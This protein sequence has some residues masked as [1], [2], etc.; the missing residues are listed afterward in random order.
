[1]R[2]I[3]ALPLPV[4]GF[5]AACGGGGGGGGGSAP[6]WVATAHSVGADGATGVSATADGGAYVTGYFAE[7]VTFAAGT[8]Q[9]TTLTNAAGDDDVF[10]ARYDGAGT[11]LFAVRAGGPDT[12]DG[13]A[14]ATAPNGDAFVAGTFERSA[15][16]GEGAAAQTLVT[17]PSGRGAFLARYAPD[18]TLRWVRG[19]EGPL[20]A[21]ATAVAA[22]PDGSAVVTGAFQDTVVFG[23][24]QPNETTLVAADQRDVFL[25][26]YDAAG[27]LAFAVRAGGA[28]DDYAYGV[29]RTSDGALVVAGTLSDTATFG[30]GEPLEATVAS[31]GAT[32]AFVARFGADGTFAWVR[33]FGGPLTD[34]ALAVAAAG[35]GD[36]VVTGAFSGTV[37]FGGGEPAET[38]LTSDSDSNDVFVARLAFDGTLVWARRAGGPGDDVGQGVAVAADGR[39]LVTGRFRGPA[40]FGPGEAAETTLPTDGSSLDAFVAEYA[41]GGALLR[42]RSAGGPGADEGLGVAAASDGRA[43]VVGTYEATADFSAFGAPQPLVAAGQEDVFVARLP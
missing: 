34:Y 4:V 8:P 12:D 7:P 20:D 5:L 24:G 31:A 9:E 39:V 14:V 17:G 42:A 32:D 13:L 15:T 21:A 41:A 37:V 30:E 3:R 27:D 2:A 35:V 10:L 28:G 33:T 29:A 36:L 6:A 25:A 23:A 1:M 22:L 11:L 18:G 38:A 40:V 16:F 43:L 26:R 19:T